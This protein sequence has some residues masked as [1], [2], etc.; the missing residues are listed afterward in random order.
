MFISSPAL[1]ATTGGAAAAYLIQRDS[2]QVGESSPQDLGS[3][4]L[5]ASAVVPL[6]RDAVP[7]DVPRLARESI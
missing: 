2:H 4:T 5:K 6:R 1:S 7:E 3:Q